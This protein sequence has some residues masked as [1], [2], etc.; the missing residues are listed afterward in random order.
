MKLVYDP[1][2]GEHF[3]ESIRSIPGYPH[4]D[5][6]RLRWMIFASDAL[7]RLSEI[8][9]RSGAERKHP[10]LAVMDTT[11]MHRGERS[12][13]PL[14]VETLK[15]GEW[16]VDQLVLEPDESGQVHTDMHQIEIV[17]ANLARY[18]SVLSIGSGVITDITK[19]ACHL[20]EQE[21]GRLLP[22]VVF[23]TANSVCAYTSSTAPVFINGVKRTMVSRYPDALVCDLETLSD[24][25]HEMTVAGVGDL[26]AVFVSFPDWYLAHRLGMD[27]SY[28]ELP[29]TLLGPLD[30]IFLKIAKG[31]RAQSPQ[32]MSVLAR[33]ITLGGLAMSLSHTT[34]PLSGYEHVMSH[35]LDLL[36]ARSGQSLAMHGNQVALT[37]IIGAEAY[38]LFLDEFDPQDVNIEKCYPMTEEIHAKIIE[39]FE[40]IDASGATS[41]ECW[42]DYQIKFEKWNQCRASLLTFLADWP[43]IRAQLRQ[44]TRPAWKLLEIL[45]AIDAPVRF[46]QLIPPV[47]LEN[48]KFALFNAPMIRKRLTLGDLFI[49]LDWDREDLWSQIQSA[50]GI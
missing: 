13:K 50:T 43:I 29:K 48:V 38:G 20:Y 6:I 34:T 35:V 41:L 33:L 28:T 25:P 36:H 26:L 8:L 22:Y 16:D 24:A 42:M 44:L 19:H 39:V 23:Q 12:L 32:A 3:W 5:E 2:E 47:G 18:G 49:F 7:F 31:I 11:P 15:S 40:K 1:G 27:S 30:E 45:H 14:I 10:L 46:D 17:K 4:G 21:A 37:S 9:E